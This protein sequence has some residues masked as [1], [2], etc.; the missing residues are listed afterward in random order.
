MKMIIIYASTL[1][2]TT[3]MFTNHPLIMGLMLLIQTI[4]ISLIT[5]MISP[6]F[7]FSYILFLIFVGGMLI[8]FI[9]MTS[10]ASNEIISFTKKIIPIMM[11][12]VIFWMII[13]QIQT[14]SHMQDSSMF[15]TMTN[16]STNQILKLYNIPTH[17]IIITMSSY[18]F[19]SLIAVVKIT[20]IFIGPLR[21]MN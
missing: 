4:L 3:S 15:N 11:I 19:L 18:L 2:S 17:L 14:Y 6:T 7:W 20:N 5:G 8:L 13:K 10:L 21:K 12:I 16:P 1:M 9:Y